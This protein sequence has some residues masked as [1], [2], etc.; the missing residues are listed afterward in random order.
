MMA[1]TWAPAPAANGSLRLGSSAALSH[2]HHRMTGCRR[3]PPAPLPPGIQSPPAADADSTLTGFRTVDCLL[4][5]RVDDAFACYREDDRDWMDASRTEQSCS[6][7]RHTTLISHLYADREPAR[8][9]D[10]HSRRPTDKL[11][12]LSWNPGL[13]RGFDPSLLSRTSIAR[14]M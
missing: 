8:R 10:Q 5:F 6:E 7:S 11:Q 13:A 2:R 1:L 4:R 9:S 14:G 12:I 3:P